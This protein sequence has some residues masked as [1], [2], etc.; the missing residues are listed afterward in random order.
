M[1]K[2]ILTICV[3][4]S[5]SMIN[6][7]WI[8][9]LSLQLEGGHHYDTFNPGRDANAV[10]QPVVDMQSMQSDF[11][12]FDMNFGLAANYAFSPLMSATLGYGQGALS[13]SNGSHYYQGGLWALDLGVRF[14][15][16]NL[17][18]AAEGSAWNLTPNLIYSINGY[19][20]A[21]YLMSDQTMTSGESGSAAGM[22]FGVEVEY[23]LN[24]NWSLFLSPQYRTVFNDGLDGFN[25]G[26]GADY[27]CR[28]NLGVKYRFTATVKDES[29]EESQVANVADLN[30]FSQ[31]QLSKSRGIQEG[32]REDFKADATEIVEEAK[33]EMQERLDEATDEVYS[34][35]EEHNAAIEEI[36]RSQR[37]LFTAVNKVSVFFE[38]DKS[39]LSDESRQ[40]LYRF[41]ERLGHAQ[42][43]GKFVV[44]LTAHTDETGSDEHNQELRDARATAVTSYLSEVLGLNAEVKVVTAPHDQLSD[45]TV[46]RRVDLTV[47]PIVE[48]TAE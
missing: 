31:E 27:Y 41:V 11:D 20:S 25:Y 43:Q 42:Y 28:T 23:A 47:E 15:L 5:A 26:S 32:L 33:G 6:A 12:K 35:L 19:E 4:V 18:P 8:N 36:E 34:V 48:E 22:A 3:L 45:R 38:V 10:D 7:Q 14:H 9:R 29:G 39:E 2:G 40:A 16:G 37:E 13:G 1:K 24:D 46:D 30:M 44:V 21:R 17:N